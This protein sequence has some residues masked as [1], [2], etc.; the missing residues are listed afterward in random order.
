MKHPTIR[1]SIPLI[2]YLT[3]SLIVA[4]MLSTAACSDETKLPPVSDTRPSKDS[5]I[6]NASDLMSDGSPIPPHRTTTLETSIELV[7]DG[8]IGGLTIDKDGNIY[9]A[10]L[11]SHIWKITPDGETVLYSGEFDDPSGNLVLANGDL[12]QSEWT[13]NRIYKLSPD[14]T[15]SLFSEANLNGPVGIV[16]RPDGD[17]IV[18][19]SRG[20]FLARVPQN[21]GDAEVVL[22]DD[23]MTQPNGVTI[24]Q[25]GN[26]YIADLDSGNV[27]KWTPEGVLTSIV[28]LP[29]RGNAHNVFANGMLYVNKIWDHV[30]YV[31]NPETG[32]YG[33]V[34]GTGLPGYEDGI[35][36]VAT[37]EEPNSI[38]V[39]SDGKVIYFNTHRGAMG[40]NKTARI[41]MRKLRFD[42]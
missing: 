24:D 4:I 37:I 29:G 31:V 15:R 34:T 2:R 16:Q 1:K 30:I 42:E 28:E 32:A 36:G 13:N 11:G 9:T 33:I 35:T 7:S 10:D 12:L 5:R 3:A 25:D 20:K 19:N 8:L 17:F 6:L 27:F 38:G 22:Q 18:A 14:G 21:G 26:I 41:I 39:T 23:R 40:R